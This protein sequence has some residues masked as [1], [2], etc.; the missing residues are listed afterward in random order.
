MFRAVLTNGIKCNI[1]YHET[2]VMGQSSQCQQ[3]CDHTLYRPV[4]ASDGR[5]YG[6]LIIM[7]SI[8]SYWMSQFPLSAAPEII[9]V[10]K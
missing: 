1:C 5:T 4:C 9:M 10:S 3:N 2:D 8:Y 7:V 6:K